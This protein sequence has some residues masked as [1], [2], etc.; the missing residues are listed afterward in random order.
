MVV[1][2]FFPPLRE[3]YLIRMFESI[4]AVAFQSVF[5][6]EMHQNNV[7][8]LKNIFDISTSK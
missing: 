1:F 7:I 6:S 8:F 5:C 3:N 2:V 4:V